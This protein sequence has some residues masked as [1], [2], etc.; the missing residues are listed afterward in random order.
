M[1]GGQSRNI[2][3]LS[4]MSPPNSQ[5][6]LFRIARNAQHGV[7]AEKSDPLLDS[8]I[9]EIG[10]Q[11]VRVDFLKHPTARCY[12]LMLRSDRSARVTIPP[13]GKL[14]EAKAFLERNLGWLAK[15]LQKAVEQPAGV[16]VYGNDLPVWYRG[17]QVP[18]RVDQLNRS[19]ALGDYRFDLRPHGRALSI[20]V[21]TSLWNL[22]R[23]ELPPLVAQQ[24]SRHGY[25]VKSV[26]VRNQRTRWGSC[27]PRAGISLNWR[28]VQTPDFVRDYIILHEL[29][30]LRH[31][32]HSARYWAEVKRICPDYERAEAWLKQFGPKVIRGY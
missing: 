17:E 18:L 29:A 3:S 5:W 9:V 4:E 6:E 24:A 28:L 8:V 16:R 32:N 12:R 25:S 22:A 31:L 23:R 20:Q 19:A 30:H 2:F 14:T 15:R 11:S 26:K 27:S 1:A 13:R 10:E 7:A 21:E